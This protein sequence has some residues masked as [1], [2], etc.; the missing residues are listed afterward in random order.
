M[1]AASL[2]TT[3]QRTLG[4]RPRRVRDWRMPEAM[5]E[6][7]VTL[8]DHLV[9]GIH[10]RRSE[11]VHG[12]GRVVPGHRPGHHVGACGGCACISAGTLRRRGQPVPSGHDRVHCGHERVRVVLDGLAYARHPCRRRRVAPWEVRGGC[13]VNERSCLA[14]PS[15]PFSHSRSGRSPS[16]RLMSR[17][18][19]RTRRG[20]LTANLLTANLRESGWQVTGAITTPVTNTRLPPAHWTPRIAGRS[21]EWMPPLAPMLLAGPRLAPW[22]CSGSGCEALLPRFLH[23]PHRDVTS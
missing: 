11:I 12:Q 14:S 4:D 15:W 7:G 22:C 1:V 9:S 3:A 17:T 13:F 21:T 5:R 20:S 10:V 18:A 23:R 6:G 8:S 2:A 19:P 16:A